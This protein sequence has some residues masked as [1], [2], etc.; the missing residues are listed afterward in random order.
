MA[1]SDATTRRGTAHIP[2]PLCSPLARSV[3]HCCHLLALV[4][5]LFPLAPSYQPLAPLSTPLSHRQC[6][7]HKPCEHQRGTK[8][9]S[10]SQ[11][12]TRIR[13]AGA[14]LTQH[15]NLNAHTHTQPPQQQVAQCSAI[16]GVWHNNK[17]QQGD[18]VWVHLFKQ[19]G[20]CHC[21]LSCIW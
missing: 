10:C 13:P 6:A 9:A 18:Q 19:A 5:P 7:S 21:C 8:E 3:A 14:P 2:P 20:R 4:A 15:N 11:Q 17:S 16:L 1:V 12:H